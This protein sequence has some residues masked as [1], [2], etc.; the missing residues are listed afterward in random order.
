MKTITAFLLGAT[1]LAT[2]VSGVSASHPTSMVSRARGP[3]N[4]STQSRKPILYNQNSNDEGIAI[5]S[6]NF[7][8]GSSGAVFDSQGADDFVVP[9]GHKWTVGEVDVTGV[10][11]NGK[12]PASSENVFFF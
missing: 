6:Q 11:S 7:T 12:G 8:S 1:A 9:A 3:A 4:P 5:V 10:Y 2:S